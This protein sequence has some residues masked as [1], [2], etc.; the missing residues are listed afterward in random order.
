MRVPES[1]WEQKSTLFLNSP[2]KSLYNRLNLANKKTDYKSCAT[3]TK[4]RCLRQE[5]D[6]LGK[7]K[8]NK[9]AVIPQTVSENEKEGHKK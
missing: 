3:N 7:F 8:A 2:R 9:P 6:M 4:R 5:G 1:I